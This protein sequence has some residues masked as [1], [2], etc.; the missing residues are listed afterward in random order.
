MVRLEERQR[1]TL[2][3]SRSY[4]PTIEASLAPSPLVDNTSS[5]TEKEE[6]THSS[7][8]V[9]CLGGRQLEHVAIML[10]ATV[11]FLFVDSER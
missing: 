6:E 9:E 8:L 10:G 4:K 5:K 11:L 3:K 1:D 2:Q 7:L